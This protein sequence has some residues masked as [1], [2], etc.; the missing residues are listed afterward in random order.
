MIWRVLAGLILVLIL[1]FVGFYAW[2]IRSEIPD[3]H[4]RSSGREIPRHRRMRAGP[5]AGCRRQWHRACDRR[6][7]ARHA[8][9]AG[10][11]QAGDRGL[12]LVIACLQIDPSGRH[13]P[14]C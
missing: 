11:D 12:G 7:S 10:Q 3:S 9:H 5:N 8:A 2:S 6:S 13:H 1:A 4:Y 14:L